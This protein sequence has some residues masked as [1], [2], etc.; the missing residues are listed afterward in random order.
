[1]LYLT[2]VGPVEY[3]A[4]VFFKPN[5]PTILPEQLLST[6]LAW[7]WESKRIFAPSKASVADGLELPAHRPL[8][9]L[10][11]NN[12]KSFRHE[13]EEVDADGFFRY[14]FLLGLD[15]E[16]AGKVADRKWLRSAFSDFLNEEA[17]PIR[18]SVVQEY[19]MGWDYIYVPHR[20]IDSVAKLLEAWGI[21]EGTLRR[22]QRIKG[23]IGVD[24]LN[25]LLPESKSG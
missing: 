2:E 22:V 9:R 14:I 1:M 4:V 12:A 15:A 8:T 24:L 6:D 13:I 10:S 17:G 7:Y 18:I 23:K 16:A 25:L 11:P 20:P 5:S 21:T 19:D 3:D